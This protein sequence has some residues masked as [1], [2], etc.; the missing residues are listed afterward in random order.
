VEATQGMC[1]DVEH[2]RT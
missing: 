1:A 2:L